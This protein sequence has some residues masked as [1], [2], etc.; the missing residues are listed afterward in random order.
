MHVRGDGLQQSPGTVPT[1]AREQ[2]S[3]STIRP[4]SLDW[5]DG[6]SDKEFIMLGQS[7]TAEARISPCNITEMSGPTVGSQ[8]DSPCFITESHI[9]PIATLIFTNRLN[10]P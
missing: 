7:F 8:C 2:G 6:C 4:S 3:G 10:P 5:S 9:L 1:T